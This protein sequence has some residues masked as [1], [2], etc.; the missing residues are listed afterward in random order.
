MKIVLGS[1]GRVGSEVLENLLSTGHPTKA[2]IRNPEKKSMLSRDKH[3]SVAVADALDAPSL[4]RAFQDGDSVFL[5]TPESTDSENM[6]AEIRNII[7]NYHRAISGS[8]ISKVIG[9][10]TVGAQHESGT[11][12]LSMGYLLEHGFGDL[13][14]IKIFVR[15]SYY[16]S[17][18][19]NYAPLVKEQGVLP[20]FFPADLPVYMCSPMDV[21]KFVAELMSDDS[22]K[23]G[24]YELLGPA[25]STAD[26][27]KEFSEVFRRPVS[28]QEI[29]KSEWWSTIKGFGFSDDVTRN[30]IAMT[31]AVIDGRSSPEGN[32]TTINFDTTFSGF[33]QKQPELVS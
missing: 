12:N 17:N 31:E 33:L 15:P 16:Y 7:D 20:T 1:T 22:A 23:P 6:V 8:K 10:S 5:L 32:H 13:D 3:L 18:W 4:Q 27:A 21:G 2:V 28:V 11:G 9:L 14:I 25:C 26:I 29:P 24:V 19:L 30:F